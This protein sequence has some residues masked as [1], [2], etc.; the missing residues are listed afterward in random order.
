MF[1]E[2]DAKDYQRNLLARRLSMK[3][4]AEEIIGRPSTKKEEEF[5][6]AFVMATKRSELWPN[7]A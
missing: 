4:A 6:L 1:P 3:R 7:F 5:L 2:F